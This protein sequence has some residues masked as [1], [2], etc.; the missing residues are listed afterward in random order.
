MTCMHST[1]QTDAARNVRHLR[2]PDTRGRGVTR[3]KRKEFAQRRR[4]PIISALI[5]RRRV[6]SRT[7]LSAERQLIGTE[8]VPGVNWLIH[9]YSARS[10][11]MH[12]IVVDDRQRMQSFV[13]TSG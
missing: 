3:Q 4:R 2:P 7:L 13:T 12:R 9:W 5:K 8:T 11:L 1:R 6:R 10:Q